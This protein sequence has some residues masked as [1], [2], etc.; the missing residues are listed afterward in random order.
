MMAMMTRCLRRVASA[1]CSL[2]GCNGRDVL[3]GSLMIAQPLRGGQ[4]SWWGVGAI[5]LSCCGVPQQ[6]FHLDKDSERADQSTPLF[7]LTVSNYRHCST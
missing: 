1:P 3:Q 2:I 6:K 4:E 5:H 7:Y